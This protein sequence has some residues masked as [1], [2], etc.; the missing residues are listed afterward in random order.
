VVCDPHV[1]DQ[2]SDGPKYKPKLANSNRPTASNG[3]YEV[4]GGATEVTTIPA[5]QPFKDP[6]PTRQVMYHRPVD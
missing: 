4:K 6:V 3:Q 5:L 1:E 2:W